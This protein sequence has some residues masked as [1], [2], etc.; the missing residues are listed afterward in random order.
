MSLAD[1]LAA[2]G[3]VA[4]AAAGHR[5]AARPARRRAAPR[6]S[7]ARPEALGHPRGPRHRRARR[8]RRAAA[9]RRPGQPPR[10]HADAD[11]LSERAWLLVAAVVGA[12]VDLAEPPAA[13]HARGPR[14]ARRRAR[15]PGAARLPGAGLRARRRSRSSARSLFEEQVAR[16]RPA[17]GA[18]RSSS[19]PSCSATAAGCASRSAPT[20]RC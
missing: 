14:G 19:P 4:G 18:A 15:R 8:R 10:L 16:H 2:A 9:R 11:A 20:T 7:R 5:P 6:R 3:G 17:A 12:L 13:R 1:E